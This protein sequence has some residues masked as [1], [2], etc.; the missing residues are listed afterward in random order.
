[1][2]GEVLQAQKENSQIVSLM[3]SQK[4]KGL[5]RLNSQNGE[6][7]TRIVGILKLFFKAL[8]TSQHYKTT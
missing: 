5:G 2:F 3:C 6:G 4:H 8:F 1:M 7:R